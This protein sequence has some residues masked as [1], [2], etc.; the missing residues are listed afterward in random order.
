MHKLNAAVKKEEERRAALP[1]R[2]AAAAA[3]ASAGAPTPKGKLTEHQ[4]A[5]SEFGLYWVADMK[6]Q[7]K[8]G[9]DMAR[10]ESVPFV[11]DADVV[12]DENAPTAKSARTDKNATAAAP[13]LR[14]PCR[15]LPRRC[16]GCLQRR[17]RS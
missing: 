6:E 15:R 14:S 5:L 8:A 17:I 16:F 13:V 12:G 7:N 2:P 3:L 1:K 10:Q 9:G 4:A 11:D